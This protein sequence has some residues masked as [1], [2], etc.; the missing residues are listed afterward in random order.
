M[1]GKFLAVV[2][3]LMGVAGSVLAAGWGE[4]PFK[5]GLVS[6]SGGSGEQEVAISFRVPAKHV[7][8]AD[9]LKFAPATAATTLELV[10]RPEP[11]RKPDP[12]MTDEVVAVYSSDFVVRYKV[13]SSGEEL[14]AIKIELQ[15]C[16]ESTCF[17][18]EEHIYALG[19]DGVWQKQGAAAAGGTSD[20]ASDGE[21]QA[22]RSVFNG[23]GYMNASAFLE[24]LDRSEGRS[25]EAEVS[26]LAGF[27][28]DPVAFMRT[29]GIW[30]TLLLVLLGGLLLNL[31]PCVLPM[32]PVNLAIIGAGGG[33][34]AQGFTRGAAYG[35][36]M[37]LVYG[38]TGW[39]ILR[40]GLFFGAL[41]SSPWFSLAMAVIFALLSLALFDV[42]VIDFSRWQR[43]GGSQKQGVVAAM[44]AGGISALLAGACV[45]PVVLA[46][47]LLAG[48]L[49]ASGVKAAQFLPFV[50]GLGM[51]LPWPLA[52]AGLSV[53]P[54]P[55]AWMVRV[56]QAF[57]VLLVALA[58][59]Y[60]W[61][62]VGG[63]RAGSAQVAREG[64]ILA[65]DR[66]AWQA[67]VAEAARLEKPLLVDFWA[68]WCKNC[69]AMERTTFQ[70]PRVRERLAGYHVVKVQAERPEESG[71]R[72]MLQAFGI[73]GLPGFVTLH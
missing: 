6:E 62:A 58:L 68:T 1:R 4:S 29:N 12:I 26:G 46:V 56:K 35:G 13:K 32:I 55:G 49:L 60:G 67:E 30:L 18:P 7:L 66:E 11:E 42:I 39:L 50:L 2:V 59:Y 37:V 15:G 71:T 21:W 8:Y 5:I 27:L 33:T 9:E 34:R 64:S 38:G 63:F 14:P 19:A 16:D 3:L 43:G 17:M 73:R 72:E 47:L 61:L 20:T 57:G 25:G 51:A 53:L 31:T 10:S 45:A 70:D 41:Q 52:G 36:G 65:G 24:W 28:A 54:K 40:S 48:S 22:G 69:S 44:I 23:G